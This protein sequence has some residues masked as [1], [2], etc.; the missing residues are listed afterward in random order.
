MFVYMHVGAYV[1][2][3]EVSISVLLSFWISLLPTSQFSAVGIIYLSPG[4]LAQILG[5]GFEHLFAYIKR[6]QHCVCMTYRLSYG[7]ISLLLVLANTGEKSSVC[8]YLVTESSRP[9]EK[10]KAIE[11]VDVDLP[12]CLSLELGQ[13]SPGAGIL[14]WLFS[15]L[16]WCFLQES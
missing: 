3:S 9:K 8:V 5:F 4:L 6:K 14:G 10:I 12:V 1:W 16:A 13:P 7:K 11:C 15:F 2:R